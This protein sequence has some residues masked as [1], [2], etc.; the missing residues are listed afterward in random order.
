MTQ[1][2]GGAVTQSTIPWITD[3]YQLAMQFDATASPLLY[4]GEALP[5][6]STS[7]AAWRI[8]CIDTTSGVSIKWAGGVSTF[9]YRW[10]DR[11]LLTYY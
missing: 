11:A 9:T 6:T 2:S 10:T 3:Q 7:T 4:L 1:P 5:G 8:Q